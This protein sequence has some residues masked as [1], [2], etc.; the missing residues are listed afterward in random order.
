MKTMQ[1]S[2]QPQSHQPERIAAEGHEQDNLVV[3]E[4]EQI[5]TSSKYFTAKESEDS[6]FSQAPNNEVIV[7]PKNIPRM[8]KKT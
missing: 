8:S 2:L 6:D 5:S 7:C 1:E 4:F 3:A